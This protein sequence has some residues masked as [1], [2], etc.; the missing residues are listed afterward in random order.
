MHAPFHAARF[1]RRWPYVLLTAALL[2]GTATAGAISSGPAA[3]APGPR[4]ADVSPDLITSSVAWEGIDYNQT[5]AACLPADVQ[6]A[7]G[8]GYVFEM[9]NGSYSIWTTVGT[10]EKSSTLDALFGAGTDVLSDP[11]VRF[12]SMAL[13][14]FASVDDLHN[15]QI[16]Y[17]SS[18]T[19]DPT[20]AW[21]IQHFSPP[22]GDVPERSMLGVDAVAVVVSTSLYSHSTGAF[23]GD[24]V[25]VANKSELM[26]G[27]GVTTGSTTPTLSQQALYPAEPLGYSKSIYLVSDGLG[28]ST[29]LELY[30]LN[31][32]P[33]G[34]FTL[35]A[36]AVFGSNTTAA[37]NAVQAGTTDLV[38]VGDGRVQS[39]VW[40]NGTLW[41][42]ATAGCVPPQDRAARSCLQL[43]EIAT[44]SS[45]LTQDFNWS[46]GAGTYDFYPALSTNASGD[47]TVVFG[48]SSAS[49][50]PSIL[51]TGQTVADLGD[52]LEPAVV[53][54]EGTGPD[55]VGSSCPGGVCPFGDTFGAAFEPFSANRFWL[56]GEYNGT[57]SSSD[58]WQTWIA[59]VT[60]VVTYPVTFSET[61][62]PTGTSW[63]VTVDGVAQASN[64]SSID[65]LEP[66]GSYSD[67]VLT[68]IPGTTGSRF[69]ANLSTGSFVVVA[70][71]DDETIGFTQQFLLT[72]SVLPAMS[73]T[74]YPDGGWMNASSSLSVGALAGAGYAFGGWSGGGTG[75]YSGTA[76]P[77]PL[78]MAGPI[79]ESATFLR[80]TTFPVTF[81]ASGLPS[82]ISWSAALNGLVQSSASTSLLF[83]ATNGSYSYN[84]PSPI[85]GPP[86]VE[87]VPAPSAGSFAV[88]GGAVPISI[89][90][91]TE[92]R[93]VTDGLPAGWGEVA[94]S[95]GWFPL[96][97]Q[98]N[99]SAVP[100]AGHEFVGWTGTGPGNYTGTADPASVT[101]GGPITETADLQSV[102]G[103]D[104]VAILT[105]PVGCG[106]VSIGGNDY[107]SGATISVAG[108]TYTVAATPCGNHTLVS[109][110][111]TD[112]AQISGGRLL[113]SGNGSIT[114]TFA[115]PPSAPNS[116]SS[117]VD[118]P[119]PLW[120]ALLGLGVLVVLLAVVLVPRRRP[121]PK[122]PPAVAAWTASP[123]DSETPVTTAVPTPG[124]PAWREDA[125]TV[126]QSPSDRRV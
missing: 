49:L 86:G 4:G 106:S 45:T 17:G 37:P 2:V 107:A 110:V 93:L 14:W 20:G 121:P 25:W 109:F 27:S 115:S 58:Y 69:V 112:G 68:P 44:G 36:P 60:N 15:D 76:N 74:V 95:D 80:S 21:N 89:G 47:L 70:G 12:D 85:L 118:S 82:G 50:D 35:P 91:T 6:V 30:P 26:S 34:I 87:Y 124:V 88:S 79:D 31:G 41:A 71:G 54:K 73:G 119:V 108:G 96:G 102:P 59:S 116:L 46:T 84:V 61:G 114:A 72:V 117:G 64:G 65:F 98:V 81:T 33:S 123:V 39:A 16:L 103:L 53:L 42:A 18:Q 5:C 105:N 94:P 40:R 10:L 67:S 22:G 101:I 1:V 66:P 126:E 23:L 43:W 29:S 75:S 24:Q 90:F 56:A 9:V 77:A 111:G 11:Q 48:E 120:A 19:S 8:S 104:V 51:V 32:S 13:R 78:V 28:N 38:D 63:S 122:V 100:T 52:G 3:S 83:N 62:L 7:S 55:T 57:N 113:V 92:F 97:V 99:V 125:E